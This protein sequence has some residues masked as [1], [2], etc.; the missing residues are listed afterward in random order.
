MTNEISEQKQR[1]KEF[2]E[3]L[4]N[5]KTIYQIESEEDMWEEWEEKK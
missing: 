1:V 5:G 4:G 3:C 2:L